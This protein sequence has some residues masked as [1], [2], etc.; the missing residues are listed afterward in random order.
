MSSATPKLLGGLVGVM[1]VIV[2]VLLVMGVLLSGALA[3]LSGTGSGMGCASSAS[4][5]SRATASGCVPPTG[6]AG[7]VVQLALHMAAHLS[8]NPACQG[9]ASFPNCYDTWYD[10]GFPQTVLAYGQRFWPGSFAWRNGT[11]Q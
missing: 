2:L 1:V 6:S 5:S 9:I 4:P 10:I 7:A 3:L 11:F 8:M